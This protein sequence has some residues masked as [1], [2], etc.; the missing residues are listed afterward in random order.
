[1]LLSC[2]TSKDKRFST[3]ASNGTP[4]SST[5]IIQLPPNLLHPMVGDMLGGGDLRFPAKDKEGRPSGNAS[6]VMVKRVKNKDYLF[7][8]WGTVYSEICTKTEPS[9]YPGLK[10]GKPIQKYRFNSRCLAV[11]TDFHALWYVSF[12]N[13]GKY[14]KIVPHNIEEL[15][16]PI[17]LA[18][19]IMADGFGDID[20]RTA[21]LCTD[22][23]TKKEVEQLVKVLSNKFGLIATIIRRTKDDGIICW[24][25]RF[26]SK[27]KN[28]TNLR[29]I[30]VP[31]MIPSMLYKVNIIK[32]S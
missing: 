19:W 5:T 11:L 6:F 14:R 18:H 32:F 23:F 7:H 8:L 12:S 1:M 9:P 15:L 21:T 29:A 16:T 20:E 25:I 10:T 31:H 3:I 28:I 27:S 22:N 17:G 26:S 24:R 13:P 2:L 30:V 4:D